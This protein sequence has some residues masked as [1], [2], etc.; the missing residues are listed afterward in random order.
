MPAS[1]PLFFTSPSSKREFQRGAE[2]CVGHGN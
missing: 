1:E 2:Q